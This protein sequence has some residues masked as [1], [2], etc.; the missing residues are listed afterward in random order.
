MTSHSQV[1][2]VYASGEYV[3]SI[4][5]S[6]SVTGTLLLGN[7]LV[8]TFVRMTSIDSPLITLAW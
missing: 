4:S 1:V 3:N 6:G 5:G 2:I 7:V 8:A